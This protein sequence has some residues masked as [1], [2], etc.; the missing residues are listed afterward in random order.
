M[1][2][3]AYMMENMWVILTNPYNAVT[4]CFLNTFNIKRHLTKKHLIKIAEDL[5]RNKLEKE[6]NGMG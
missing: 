5:K 2:A 1:A 4:D 3:E 6:K